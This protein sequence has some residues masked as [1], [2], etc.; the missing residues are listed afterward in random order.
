MKRLIIS[1]QC[2]MMSLVPLFAQDSKVPDFSMKD[3][4][5]IPV[6][7]TWK[8][9]DIY[10]NLDAWK[11]D[12]QNV[13]GLV[14][15][16]DGMSKDW[17]SSAAKMLAFFKLTDEI[18]MK[19]EKLY[20]YVSLQST[21]DLGNTTFQALKGE[22]MSLFVDLG[23]KLSFV[24]EDILK[25]GQDKFNAYL[26]QEPGLQTYKFN[27]EQV[28]RVK[29]HILPSNEQKIV[30]L[31]GL[32][33]G[34]S[35]EAYGVLSNVELPSPE[36]T[37]S[38][39]TKI[40]LNT[41]N[42]VKYRASKNP[43]DRTLVMNAYWANYKKFENTFAA[44]L[45]G[46]IKA[47]WF[48][49]QVSKY[50]T[51]LEASLDANNID[52]KVYTQLIESVNAHLG[53]L[54]RYLKLKQSLLGLE[55]YRY[56]D[57]YASAVKS[58]NKEY[59][60]EE[61]E[62]LVLDCMKPLGDDY[63]NVLK[64]AFAERWVDRY[65][66]K[67]KESG[68]FSMGIYAVHPFVKMNY[69]GEYDAVSTLAHELGHTM[70]S[71][72]SS[73]K[74][75][76]ATNDYATFLAEIASTFNENLLMQHLLKTETDDLYKLYILDRYLDGVRATIFRQTLFA[77]FE[78][79]MHTRVEQGQ[80]LTADWLDAEYLS[81]TRKYYG[82]DKGV[83]EVGDY[84][85]NEW[86]YIP[87][88]YMNYYVFQ[89]ATG[90]IASMALSEKV[91]SGDKDAVNKYLTFLSAGGSDYPL[92]ILKNAGVDMTQPEASEAAFRNFDNLVTEMEKIVDRLKKAG[93]L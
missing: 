15:K 57:I 40:T 74:Q 16:I 43:A 67:G 79:A 92:N 77:E 80:T 8:V 38:D 60:Y 50:P 51:C 27:V 72:L 34:A 90:I 59:S 22:I 21:A 47:H 63:V 71:Y 6:E 55:K 78:L 58:V 68:A 46:E 28:L 70:H 49:A 13:E 20:C 44:M 81:L 42:Y 19:G 56:D 52:P 48:N 85:Q 82:A 87:H 11:A 61:G 54:H 30:S 9:E 66:N 3:R 64:K 24:N 10:A 88:F 86:S 93:K 37:L 62:K 14:A 65:P 29:D 39:G 91:L 75:P 2:M 53:S 32:F 7:Y 33:S 41:A 83:V 25:L 26:A 18:S 5:D 35:N 73:K 89:Y 12:K 76:F 17:T 23:S 4:K 1:I 31:T 45:N 36:V 69:N 84:I